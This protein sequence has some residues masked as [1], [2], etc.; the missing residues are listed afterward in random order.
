MKSSDLHLFEAE[1]EVGA[2]KK[3][4]FRTYEKIFACDASSAEFL[5]RARYT[6]FKVWFRN[7]PSKVKAK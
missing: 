2:G 6:E 4:R 7:G 5:L 3:F 1:F